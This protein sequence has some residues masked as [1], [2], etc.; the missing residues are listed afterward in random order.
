MTPAEF[1]DAYIK[2]ILKIRYAISKGAKI[3]VERVGEIYQERLGELIDRLFP[4]GNFPQEVWELY[5]ETRKLIDDWTPSKTTNEDHKN[6]FMRLFNVEKKKKHHLIVND[7][8]A[9]NLE[10]GRCIGMGFIA[11]GKSDK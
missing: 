9:R 4:Q 2:E 10:S 7:I 6:L 1:F 5:R 11:H 3:D 8:I